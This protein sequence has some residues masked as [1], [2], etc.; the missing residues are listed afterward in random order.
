MNLRRLPEWAN[1]AACAGL[2]T[3]EKD[4]W[5]PSEDLTP[6]QRGFELHLAR[7]IC[8]HCPVR[9]ECVNDELAMLDQVAP[10]SMRGGLTPDELVEAAK[11]RGLPYRRRAQCGTRSKYVAGCRCD[12]CRDAHRVYEHERRLWAKSRPKPQIV[13]AVLTVP[14]GRGHRRAEPGQLVLFTTGLPDRSYEKRDTA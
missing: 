14:I 6:E 1:D 11:F 3:R 9:V 13:F 4:L 5:T 2:V 7:T 12:R 10:E 8:A